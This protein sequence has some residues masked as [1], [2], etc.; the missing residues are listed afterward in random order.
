MTK[1]KVGKNGIEID[2]LNEI[3]ISQG[4]VVEVTKVYMST[5]VK[6]ALFNA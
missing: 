3:N 2:Q 6:K 4:D 5:R 1:L